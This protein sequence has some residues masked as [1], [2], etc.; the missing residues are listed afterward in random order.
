LAKTAGSR[1]FWKHL[2]DQLGDLPFPADFSVCT[3]RSYFFEVKGGAKMVSALDRKRTRILRRDNQLQPLMHELAHLYLD[4]RW[5]VL[6]YSVS[7]P[8][9]LAMAVPEK[10]DIT[11]EKYAPPEA[12]QNAWKN[13]A[14][15]S[16]CEQLNL[17]RTVLQTEAG[18]RD[19][20]PLR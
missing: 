13:R 16:R 12:M 19:A 8:L 17:L 1:T 14:N 4:L 10:C 18:V 6:P 9:V 3:G 15:L 7:E 11:S 2:T 5:K 20:L